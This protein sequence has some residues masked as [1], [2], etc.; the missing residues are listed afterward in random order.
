MK[1]RLSIIAAVI[2]LV[3]LQ[4]PYLSSA[5]T[6]YGHIITRQMYL[7]DQPFHI[8]DTR[9]DYQG[10]CDFET[11]TVEIIQPT[12]ENGQ[13]LRNRPVIFFV[14]GGAW[15]N[16]YA[17]RYT[18][19]LTPVFVDIKGWVAV[20]VDYRLTSD[21]VFPYNDNEADP[22]NPKMLDKAAWYGDNLKDVAAA[23]EWTVNHIKD[24]GGDP[25]NIFLFGHSA[26]GHLISL[27][28]THDDYRA[29]RHHMRGI[30]T[31][32]G[33]YDLNTITHLLDSNINQTFQGGRENKALL[34]EASPQ[35]YINS[36]EVLPPFYV[37]Y[38]Q[39]DIPSFEDQANAFYE[40]LIS[41]NFDP[42][43][44]YLEG[45]NHVSEMI[46]IGN[47]DAE[48]TQKIIDYVEN[49]IIP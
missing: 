46:S 16:D 25:N 8:T 9:A 45:E 12:D 29:L 40:K 17:E 20:N 48:A 31:M 5:T 4:P 10:R 2:L 7:P 15:T 36:R 1:I 3:L 34:K 21:Q 27:L 41:E 24:Y 22:C 49:H 14:H 28:A 13:S 11:R 39:W 44:D 42:K 18:A 33:A 47:P 19:A 35:T 43:L 37:L 23:F 32:S 38:C 26:G 6:N 30:I